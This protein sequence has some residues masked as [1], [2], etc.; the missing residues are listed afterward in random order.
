M[1]L[2]AEAE[3]RLRNAVVTLHGYNLGFKTA[4]RLRTVKNQSAGFVFAIIMESLF[5]SEPLATERPTASTVD[6]SHHLNTIAKRRKPSPLKELAY[7]QGVKGMKSFA[8][9]DLYLVPINEY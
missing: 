2:K 8:G 9:G 3:A 1:R 7:Y 6:L 4:G 5:I